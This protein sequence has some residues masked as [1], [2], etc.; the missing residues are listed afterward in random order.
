MVGG[1]T[2]SPNFLLHKAQGYTAA[3]VSGGNVASTIALAVYT[4]AKSLVWSA[5]VHKS[6][7]VRDSITLTGHSPRHITHRHLCF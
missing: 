1:C 7:R 6:S 2:I 3:G 5:G 4:T